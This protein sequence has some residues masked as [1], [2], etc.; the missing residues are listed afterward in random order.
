MA[1]AKS[2]AFAAAKSESMA[3]SG[4]DWSTVT[5]VD[6]TAGFTVSTT[7]ESWAWSGRARVAEA[8]RGRK[9]RVCMFDFGGALLGHSGSTGVN[10]GWVIPV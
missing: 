2:P 6:P 3:L 4:V 9:S 1:E 8:I 5:A 7:G 10:A